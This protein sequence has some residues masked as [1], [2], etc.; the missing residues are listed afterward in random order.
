MQT[1]DITMSICKPCSVSDEVT[2]SALKGA[3]VVVVTETTQ[4]IPRDFISR[5]CHL[6]LLIRSSV[7]MFLVPLLVN[8]ITE[9][10]VTLVS[11]LNPGVFCHSC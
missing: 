10:L 2:C 7:L 8:S 3:D 4:P 5:H 11:E 1:T 6:L 9:F